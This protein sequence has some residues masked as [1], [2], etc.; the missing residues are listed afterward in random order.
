MFFS[1]FVG[2]YQTSIREEGGVHLIEINSLVSSYIRETIADNWLVVEDIAYRLDASTPNYNDDELFQ[3]LSCKIDRWFI[4]EIRLYTRD[5]R[6]YDKDEKQIARDTAAEYI[7]LA[8]E[9]GRY[10]QVRGSRVMFTMAVDNGVTYRDSQVVA[11]S[12]GYDIGGFI[13]N[14][15]VN[16]SMSDFSRY[17]LITSVVMIV[18]FFAILLSAHIF[19][20]RLQKRLMDRELSARERLFDLLTSNGHEVY[21][22]YSL[23]QNEP[24]F[25]SENCKAILGEET[26]LFY[27]EVGAVTL[28]NKE[29][30]QSP[31]LKALGDSYSKWDGVGD[32]ITENIP[33]E[34]NGERRIISAHIYSV[35]N[36]PELYISVTRDV[37]RETEH[38]E[39][40]RSALVLAN[41]ANRA[42]TSFLANMSHDIRTPMN[43]IINMTAF[44]RECVHDPEKQA[45]YL[46]IVQSSSEH[47]L[48]LIND[49]LEVSRIESGKTGVANS[50]FSMN[51]C[52]S[53]TDLA[54]IFEPFKRVNSGKT[55]GIEGTG[56]GLSITHGFVTAMGGSITVTSEQGRGSEFV[57]ELSF[58]A[59]TVMA[60][61]EASAAKRRVDFSGKRV[62]L[63]EDNRINRTVAGNILRSFGIELEFAVDGVE[64]VDKFHASPTGYYDIIFMDI[65]M[66]GRDGYE[67]TREIRRSSHPDAASVPIVAMTANAFAEDVEKTRSAGMNGHV[68]KPIDVAYLVSVISA[69]LNVNEN[70][71]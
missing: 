61:T 25:Q 15:Q 53:Q 71:E 21:S 34:L 39:A 42:K 6:G 22:L 8:N 17:V 31:F 32:Y 44:A 65:Q 14:A 20:Y 16:T 45:E 27:G 40:L 23:R 43:A 19:V 18:M 58:D 50:P 70:N 47:L 2:R 11:V 12:V 37:T 35:P 66:P 9:K 4:D 57:V 60:A 52:I 28:K 10:W 64:G 49:V 69:I 3:Y 26:V 33:A 68:A 67:A 7:A 41:S 55:E 59:D 62:L 36:D 13:E 63:C 46:D 5:G 1:G 56:L 24:V 48:R 54:D 30:E 38:A 51:A 29:G